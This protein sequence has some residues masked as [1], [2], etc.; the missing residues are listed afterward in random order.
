MTIVIC[1]SSLLILISK[2]ELLDLMI[3]AFKNV[4]IPQAVFIE[5]VEQ[6]K[7]LKKMDAF[8]IEKTLKME[9]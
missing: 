9:K 7:K 6:G 3:E 2:L 5:A 8:L 1:D 4:L